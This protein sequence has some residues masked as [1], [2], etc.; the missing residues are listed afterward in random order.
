MLTV[1]PFSAG[2]SAKA[3][4][5]YVEQ[6]GAEKY[7]GDGYWGGEG[8][9]NMGLYGSLEA[10]EL[11][12]YLAGRNPK[13]AEPLTKKVDEQHK[14]GWDLTFSAPKSVSV[15]W[16]ADQT[17]R[18]AITKAHEMSVAAAMNYLEKEAFFTRH[19]HAGAEHKPVLESGGLIY[20]VHHHAATRAN[21]PGLHSHTI[22]ANMTS[23][24]RGLDFDTRHKMVAGALYRAELA[25]QMKQLGYAIDRDEKSFKIVGVNQDLVDNWSKRSDQ[26]KEEMAERGLS[27]AESAAKIAGETRAA[28]TLESEPEAFKRW[29]AEAKEFGYDTEKIKQA[30]IQAEKNPA[31]MPTSERIIVD[32][33]LKES[34]ISELQLKAASIQASQG[35][36][37]A[38]QALNHYQATVSTD[39]SLVYLQS[40]RGVRVTTEEVL[41]RETEMLNTAARLS[42]RLTHAVTP[43]QL[44]NT[45]RWNTLTKQQKE[46]VAHVTSASSLTILQ[47]W[48]GTGKTYSLSAAVEAW[49]NAGYKVVISAP[50]NNAVDELRDSIGHGPNIKYINTS[51]LELELEHN[52]LILD[53]KT[54]LLVDEAG[55]E[56][57]KRT[58]LFLEKAETHGGKLVYAG[59]TEQIQPIDSGAPMRGM[60]EVVGATEL[61]HESV[62]RQKL[63]S[64]KEI[65]KDIREGRGADAISKMQSLGMVKGFNTKLDAFK[66][67]VEGYVKSL[68]NGKNPILA[69]YTNNEVNML[70]QY[71]RETLKEKGV[72]DKNGQ[73]FETSKGVKEFAAGDKVIFLM[74]HMFDKNNKDTYVKNNNRGEVLSVTK[75]A[76]LVKL[77]KT[78]AVVK[79]EMSEFNAL[80][81]GFAATIHKSQGSTRDETHKLASQHDSKE[82]WYVSATRHK[83]EM[84]VY[85]TKDLIEQ[86]KD[87]IT[88]KARPSELE[89]SMERSSAKDLSTDYVRID[90]P[91]QT[92]P[93]PELPETVQS[94]HKEQGQEQ[95]IA[96]PSHETSI[97][98]IERKENTEQLAEQS[99]AN[100]P[101]QTSKSADV[102]NTQVNKPLS[103]VLKD[104]AKEKPLSEV[105][106][107]R[108]NQQTPLEQ[109][110]A[111]QQ[112][113]TEAIKT[114]AIQIVLKVEAVKGIENAPSKNVGLDI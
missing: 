67:A 83:D 96:K 1:T 62:I 51:L 48:A 54:I 31:Q 16:A 8:A 41:S 46:A 66:S 73:E 101:G 13:T 81:H 84:T 37:D 15:I 97:N 20:S 80:T 34:T 57:S 10:G 79:I 2:D 87:Q 22:V 29:Q 60:M 75:S 86:E 24:G 58:M 108:A 3:I 89:N 93:S 109:A 65:A 18:S 26:I 45:S 19:G 4:A 27:G 114:N 47:G 103:E 38:S 30:G 21:D 49:Q 59:D 39:A 74:K 69:A 76:M 100:T 113:I 43:E 85:A 33:M 40:H 56:G 9:K 61:G 112:K 28:K 68:D 111:N 32:L 94:V 64:H 70:N 5:N 11:E 52:E 53:E 35:H 12:N 91:S 23:D 95:I 63:Q 105:L 17:E 102:A 88:G 78:Q 44:K 14:P 82:S 104:N 71:V 55:M 99:Q 72:V 107:D 7:Y 77:D 110:R 6:S 42:N 98:V 50:S 36:Q 90:P 106:K 25:S 92:P